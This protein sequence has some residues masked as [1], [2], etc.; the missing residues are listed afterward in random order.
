MAGGRPPFYETIEELDKK[1]AEYWNYILGDFTE[2]EHEDEEGVT[3]T[4]KVYTRYPEHPSVTGLAL[5]LGFTSRQALLNYEDK[6]EFVDS[7]KKAK[8]KVEHSYE[9]A[10]H[11]RNQAG[12]IFALKNFG[13]ADKQEIDQKTEHSGG[14]EIRWQDPPVSDSTDKGSDGVL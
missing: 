11:G 9:Q 2:E 7:V 13:W 12:P 5:Y 4:R 3:F 6:P 14:I 10:L 1:I 8:L